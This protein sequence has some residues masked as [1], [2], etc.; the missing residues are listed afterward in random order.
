MRSYR[1]GSEFANVKR[2]TRRKPIVG[3]IRRKKREHPEADLQAKCVY[4]VDVTQ[5]QLYCFAIR[6]EGVRSIPE[7][8]L[9]LKMG[10]RPGIGDLCILKPLKLCDD[11]LFAIA[12]QAFFVECKDKGKPL[13][14]NQKQFREFCIRKAIPYTSIETVEEFI[15]QLNKWGLI[16]RPVPLSIKF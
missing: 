9:A 11:R 6:N 4:F 14:D 10:M 8:M 15:L 16:T 3:A 7:T 13:N 1:L 2:K 12:W 5:P